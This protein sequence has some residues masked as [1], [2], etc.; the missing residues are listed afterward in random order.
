[1]QKKTWPSLKKALAVLIGISVGCYVTRVILV[2]MDY[3]LF[4][5]V[6]AAYSVPWYTHI[7]AASV[8]WGIVILLEVLAFL[9]VRHKASKSPVIG[10][11][12][13]KE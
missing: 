3:K 6:Y 7:I 12:Q 5:D 4:P 2:L 13:R 10:V 8:C 9:F 11:I 1:M